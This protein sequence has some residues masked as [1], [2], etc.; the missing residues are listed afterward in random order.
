MELRCSGLWMHH[1]SPTLNWILCFLHIFSL[2]FKSCSENSF[3]VC[4][5]KVFVIATDSRSLWSDEESEIF[6]TWMKSTEMSDFHPVPRHFSSDWLVPLPR[7]RFNGAVW[8]RELQPGGDVSVSNRKND[9]ADRRAGLREHLWAPSAPRTAP[10][11]HQSK[12][13][14]DDEDD[15]DDDDDDD[16]VSESMLGS[17]PVTVT[18]EE[19]WQLNKEVTSHLKLSHGS[20]NRL[21]Q[22]MNMSSD[23]RRGW[24]QTHRCIWLTQVR[25]ETD[26]WGGRQT[27]E[28]WNRQVTGCV[29]T[30]KVF[31]TVFEQTDKMKRKNYDF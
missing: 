4:A 12:A 30:V 6:L 10:W 14:K 28:G 1:R 13:Q 2:W 23:N 21:H 15:D 26:R 3:A 18:R 25:R 11:I 9:K 19:G 27:G 29:I 31:W 16:S 20:T 5:A 7:W 8:K 17:E 22:P 24:K